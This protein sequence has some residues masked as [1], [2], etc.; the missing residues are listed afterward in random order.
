[1]W[2]F[3]Y[4]KI[5]IYATLDIS[6][7]RCMELSINRHIEC[8][9][10]S[11]PCHPGISVFFIQMY[12]YIERKLHVSNIERVYVYRFFEKIGMVSNS[13]VSKVSV[14]RNIERVLPS[15]PSHPGVFCANL[16]LN[17]SLDLSNIEIVLVRISI[18]FLLFYR[19]MSYRIRLSFDIQHY[20]YTGGIIYP[21]MCLPFHGTMLHKSKQKKKKSAGACADFFYV[22]VRTKKLF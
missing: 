15:I 17:E 18:S 5:S 4:I 21:L 10:P 3:R 22:Q 12:V 20:W 2:K 6:K 13:D 8:V 9:L 7:Y 16:M 14:Y 1:M 19:C 11:L